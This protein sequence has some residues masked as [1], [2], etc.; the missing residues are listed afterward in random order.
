MR[1][2][3]LLGRL[4]LGERVLHRPGQLSGG[5]QQRVSIARALMNGG[6]VILADEPTGRSTAS[7]AKVMRI[8]QELHADG[9]TVII[10]THDPKVANTRSASSRWLMGSS[11]LTACRTE[12]SPFNTPRRRG[13]APP[14]PWRANRDRFIEAFTMALRAMADIASAHLADRL[15]I[16]IGIASVVSMAALGEGSRQR[17]LKD[18]SAMGTNTIDIFPG[19]NFGDRRA[20][21]I[22]TL[23]QL[24]PMRWRS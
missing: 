24:M 16:T 11:C 10:V 7:A 19:K 22:R 15:G 6:D 23:R 17:V 14:H 4:G 18:I 3:A 13:H 5:Q 1:A 12:I 20:G 9:H 21:R 2:A 8:L